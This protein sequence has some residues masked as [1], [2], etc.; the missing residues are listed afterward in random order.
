MIGQDTE[1]RITELYK[2]IL[3]NRPKVLKQE[4][5]IYTFEC[6]YKLALIY[7]SQFFP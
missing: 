7:F 4:E 2:N 6:D 5:N 1:H 3:I